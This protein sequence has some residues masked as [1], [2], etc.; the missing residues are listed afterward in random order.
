MNFRGV[1]RLAKD[2]LSVSPANDAG[3][4]KP[5]R[6]RKR[7]SARDAD[8]GMALRSVYSRTVDEAVPDEFMDLLSKLD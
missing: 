6:R 5:V 7:D 1:G 4:S 2:D 3:G 8:V